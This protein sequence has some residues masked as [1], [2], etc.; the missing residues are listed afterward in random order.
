M[1]QLTFPGVY[2][3]ELAS[4]VRSIAGAPTSVALFVGPTKAGIDGWSAKSPKEL[5]PIRLQNFGDFERNFGGLSQTSS[6]SYSVLHFFANGG[7]EAYVLRVPASNA[8]A[9]S[10]GF[11]QDDGGATLSL[12][13]TA[14]SS[15]EASKEIFVEFDSFGLGA[16]PDKK[17]FNLNISDRL[18]GRI[19]R[20]SN[21]STSSASARFAPS[22]VNDA[23]TGSKLVAMS[24]TG[25]DKQAP[26]ATGSIYSIGTKPAAGSFASA[27]KLKV[28]IEFRDAN[29]AVDAGAAVSIDVVAFEKDVAKPTTPLELCTR[30]TAALNAA[31]R[32]DATAAGKLE[33]LSID[34][35]IFEGGTLMRFRIAPVGTTVTPSRRADGAVTL[36]AP[37]SGTSLLNTYSLTEN[38]ANPSRFQL[39]WAYASSQISGAPTAG[40][41]G[42]AHGQPVSSNFKDVVTA[43]IEPDP[44]FN[45]LCLPDAVRSSAADP[46]VPQHANCS[47]IYSEAA[48][49]C[50]KKFAFLIMDPPPNVQDVGGAEAWKTTGISFQSKHSAAYFPNIRVDDPLEPG[51][52]R[53]HPPSGAI[54][55]LFARTDSATGVWQAPAGTESVL[56]GAYG[57]SVVL[58]DEQQGIL[59]PLGLNVIRKFPVYGT[60]SFG[61]RTIDGADAMNSE[62][63]Y[64]PVRRTASY[65][66]RSLSEGLRWAVHKPNGEQLWS[67]LRVN[68]TA[69]MQGLFRQGAFKGVSSREAYFVACDSST[70]TADDIN[71]GVVNIVIGFAPL[72]PAEFVVISLRQIIQSGQ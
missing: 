12:T 51:A 70:T 50:S 24:L 11:R 63:K 42:D 38:V 57:P 48:F 25:I 3:Q 34:G 30:L 60:V 40:D 39:G 9:A 61:S 23:A 17:L 64:I 53:S 37:T 56:S 1:L 55:G 5:R 31:L 47:S 36:A 33:T 67:Q 44:F 2:T 43:L 62:W 14:L 59:N 54:A 52:I 19:E 32:A 69:F 4:G 72:R 10:S 22:V 65:I 18:T 46:L 27:Q 8:K 35:G 21:L 41:D 29:G 49:V 7:G 66:L 13:L 58:S 6:L 20:F 16:N 71:A 26:Q 68:V 28:N 45:I 15:G